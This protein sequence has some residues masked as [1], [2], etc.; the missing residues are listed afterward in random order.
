MFFVLPDNPNVKAEV[1]AGDSL[2]CFPA[3][4]SASR[5]IPRFRKHLAVSPTGDR[6]FSQDRFHG[7]HRSPACRAV[8]IHVR[9]EAH[10]FVVHAAD[11]QPFLADFSYELR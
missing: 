11:Q 9:D 10:E 5:L 1:A 8:H 3:R 6:S 4:F 2:A 7:L